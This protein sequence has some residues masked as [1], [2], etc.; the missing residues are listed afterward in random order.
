MIRIDWKLP[1]APL[2]IEAAIVMT[3]E[4]PGLRIG[5]ALHDLIGFEV[6]VFDTGYGFH[7]A[8]RRLLLFLRGTISG[9]GHGV[10]W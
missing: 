6:L 8:F 1:T 2:G 7:A 9:Q 5:Q 10:I 4:E 3:V